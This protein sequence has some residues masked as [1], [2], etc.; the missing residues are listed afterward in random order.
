MRTETCLPVR[1]LLNVKLQGQSSRCGK[2]NRTNLH[3]GHLLELIQHKM[4]REFAGQVLQTP[5]GEALRR[6]VGDDAKHVVQIYEVLPNSGY[7]IDG[8][9]RFVYTCESVSTQGSETKHRPFKSA[10]TW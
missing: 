4:H 8:L 1:D 6:S 10:Y 5:E 2:E 3:Q 9:L 7:I